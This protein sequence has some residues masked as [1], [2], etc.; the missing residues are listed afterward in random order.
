[1][2][3]NVCIIYLEYNTFLSNYQR[4]NVLNEAAW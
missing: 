2:N 3:I 1:M 4:E